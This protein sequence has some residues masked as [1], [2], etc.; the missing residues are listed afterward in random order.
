[1]SDQ[2][3]QQFPAAERLTLSYKAQED[4]LLLQAELRGD[5]GPRACWL[6]R[7]VVV[8][9][10]DQ[11]GQG[12]AATHKRARQAGSAAAEVLQM[13]HL[14][15]VAHQP[16]RSPGKSDRRDPATE[17]TP[18]PA[19]TTFLITHPAVDMRDDQIIVALSGQRRDPTGPDS[20]TVEP[21]VAVSLS[22]QGAHRL[23]RLFREQA[24]GAGWRLAREWSW[25]KRLKLGSRER[26]N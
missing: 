23:L 5:R 2:S 16:N 9:L 4:R 20:D 26:A 11:L 22:R 10:V 6:S 1:M 15:A 19:P 21:A 8:T 7:R 14:A 25:M 18:A 12:L 3:S 13:E 24:D 17:E